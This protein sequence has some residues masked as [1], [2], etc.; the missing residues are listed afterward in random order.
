MTEGIDGPEAIFDKR[1]AISALIPYVIR[2]L[3]IGVS[4]LFGLSPF[5]LLLFPIWPLVVTLS[6]CLFRFVSSVLSF[7]LRSTY[8]SFPSLSTP[9]LTCM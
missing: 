7:H 9:E 6:R 2:L 1:K 8:L 4:A 5:V 3:K